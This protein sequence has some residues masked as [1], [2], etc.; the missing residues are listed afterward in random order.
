MTDT[1]DKSQFAGIGFVRLPD[2]S[3]TEAEIVNN[4]ML[5]LPTDFPDLLDA[6]SIRMKTRRF[7]ESRNPVLAIEAFISAIDAG[8]YPPVSVLQWLAD[9]FR[10]YHDGQG[11]KGKTLEKALGLAGAPGRDPH[12][13]QLLLEERNEMLFM[14]MDML[15]YLGASREK[16]AELVADRLER[17]D[18][19]KSAWEMGDPNGSTLADT[20]ARADR[21]RLNDETA[22]LMGLCDKERVARYLSN[23]SKDR[24]PPMLK[25]LVS[26]T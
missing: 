17:A 19:N 24:L 11:V 26:N 7:K 13:K 12:F 20:H 8:V 14:D 16:S 21:A 3:Y 10:T 2:E 25:R 22:T 18:W 5:C 4:P 23:F 9:G 1:T 15:M 6:I